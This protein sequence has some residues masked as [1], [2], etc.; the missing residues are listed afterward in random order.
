MY[1]YT[2]VYTHSCI[3]TYIFIYIFILYGYAF[4]KNGVYE[5]VSILLHVSVWMFMCIQY[6]FGGR[7]ACV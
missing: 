2:N 3:C 6:E 5:L 7:S 4:L 1:A